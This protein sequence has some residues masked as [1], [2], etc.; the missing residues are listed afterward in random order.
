MT[1]S[2]RQGRAG[3]LENE[4]ILSELAARF[5]VHPAT[6]TASSPRKFCGAQ[7]CKNNV[8]QGFRS[9]NYRFSWNDDWNRKIVALWQSIYQ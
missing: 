7:F 5:G 3:G 8:V 6:I 2:S 1:M 4:D 9:V